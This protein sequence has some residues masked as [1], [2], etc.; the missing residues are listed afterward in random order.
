MKSSP[1]FPFFHTLAAV[2]PAVT[3]AAA[4]IT[5]SAHATEVQSTKPDDKKIETIIVVGNPLASTDARD[6]VS[7][8]E[9]LG[10]NDLP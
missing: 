2:L 5:A 9:V 4:T 6:V 7:P 8:V 10:A 1:R 3:F